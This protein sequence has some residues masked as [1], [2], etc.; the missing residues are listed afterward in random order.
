MKTALNVLIAL[1][2]GFGS[3]L[4]FW[5]VPVE[6]QAWVPTRNPGYVKDFT[7]NTEMADAEFLSLPDGEYGPEDIAIGPDG[8]LYTAVHSGRILAIDPD[9]GVTEVIADTGGR[10]L[11]IEFDRQ[12]TLWIADAFI[13]LLSIDAR[14]IITTHATSTSDGSPI[15]FADDVD[16]AP[17]GRVYFSDASTR[18]GAKHI[19]DTL[20]ASLLDLMEHS[21][22]GRILVFDPATQQTEV[23]AD[24]LTFA[25]GVALSADGTSL[26][27]NETGTYAVHGYSLLPD[28]YGER[29]TLLAGLPGFPDNINRMDDGTFWVGIVSPRSEAMDSLATSPL[30]R[31]MVMR[32]PTPLRPAAQRYGFVIQIDD[33]GAVLANLQDPSGAYANT[34]GATILPDGRL[35]ISSLTEPRIALLIP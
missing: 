14:G 11:G 1:I 20:A 31:K 27:V 8:R 25:N 2:L 21:A 17:D 6:P 30:L 23:F 16:I 19:G 10:P 13:G 15:L 12:G 18:F 24:G 5:P 4:V 32:L 26:L 34:T 28:N 3:Y 9:S 7:V 35:A 29:K 33:D 22:S